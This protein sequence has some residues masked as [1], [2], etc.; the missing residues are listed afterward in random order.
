MA[1]SKEAKRAAAIERNERNRGKYREH[2]IEKGLEGAALTAFIEMKIGIPQ[3]GNRAERLKKGPL[4]SVAQV[5]DQS[6]QQPAQ[7]MM[8]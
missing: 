1:Q 7:Q 3:K 2:G 4:L 8:G 6:T 5:L